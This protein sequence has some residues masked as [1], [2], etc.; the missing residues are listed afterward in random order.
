MRFL[1]IQQDPEKEVMK[2]AYGLEPTTKSFHSKNNNTMH[3]IDL[4]NS[5]IAL[6]PISDRLVK[7]GSH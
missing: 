6:S 3:C 1:T 5:K 4:N 7:D 2:S